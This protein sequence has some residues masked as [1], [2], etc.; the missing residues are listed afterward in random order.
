M[1]APVVPVVLIM[2]GGYLSWFGIHYWRSDTKWPTDPVK[3]ILT[4]NPL[5]PVTHDGEKTDQAAALALLTTPA[6]APSAPV[7]APGTLYPAGNTVG[8]TFN[9]AG[10]VTLWTANGGSTS[11]ADVAAAVGMAESSGRSAVTSANPD[12]GT[13]VGIWQ[14][15]TKGEGA[16]YTVAQLSDP[17]TNARVTVMKTANGTNWHAWE[18]WVNGAYKRF[19]S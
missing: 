4:G 3:A 19:L 6:T 14:L 13:N 16:G 7:A 11:T 2:L 18:T 15:D 10:L 17:A 1:D 12:G 5:P 8:G 9:H